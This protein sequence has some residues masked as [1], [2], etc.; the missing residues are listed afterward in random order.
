M[1]LN[2]VGVITST[3]GIKGEV[4]VKSD[5]SFDRFSVGNKL[6][7][8]KNGLTKE[9]IINS[10]RVHKGYDLITFNDLRNINDVL[11][12]VGCEIYVDVSEFD[13]LED[14]E[15]YF[16]DLIG[17]NVYDDEGALLGKVIDINE[18]PQGIILE[19]KKLDNS[20]AYI[21]FVDEFIKEINLEE[22][23]IVITPI[24]GLLWE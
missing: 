5:T 10:H 18:V 11:E 19:L 21:P 22:E 24:E 1:K 6:F 8:K 3:H 23:K 20:K 7:I 17:L 14:G 13:E 9:I 4:K 16:D 2:L 15:F 12:Y